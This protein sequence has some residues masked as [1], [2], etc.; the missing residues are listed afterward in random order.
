MAISMPETT[1]T[2][3][4]MVHAYRGALVTLVEEATHTVTELREAID[5]SH[6]CG[7]LP[8]PVA[9]DGQESLGLDDEPA[10]DESVD[11]IADDESEDVAEPELVEA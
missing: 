5:R 7:Q 11:V 9:A 4:A 3:A 1:P 8:L 2:R 6:L 10:D